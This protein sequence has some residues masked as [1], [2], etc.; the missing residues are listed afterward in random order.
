MLLGLSALVPGKDACAQIAN[1]TCDAAV[2]KTMEARARLETERE[3]MQNQNLIFKADSILNYTCFDSMAGHAA[4]TVGVLF[5]HTAYFGSQIIPWGAP[6]GMDEAMNNVV[7]KSMQQYISDNFQHSYM[8]GR[9]NPAPNGLGLGAPRAPQI[10]QGQSY[11]CNVMNQVWMAAKCMNFM[12]TT[13]FAAD[14]G[15]YPFVDLGPGGPDSYQAK[16]DRRAWPTACP[17][18]SP[19]TGSTWQDTYRD[20]RNERSFGVEGNLY[21]Y[22]TINQQVFTQVRERVEPGRCTGGVAI[23]TGVQVILSPGATQTYPDGVCTNPGCTY[24][25]GGQCQ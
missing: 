17:S 8:G 13:T 12:H 23:R 3:I 24:T 16:A 9:G 6:Y 5:T 20:S 25:Q 15:F 1:Q 2:W 7:G 19:I 4:T 14:D 21:R 11:G 22:Q 18:A 10:R